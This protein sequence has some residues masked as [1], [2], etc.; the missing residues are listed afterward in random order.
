MSWRGEPFLPH[1]QLKFSNISEWKAG[2]YLS[3]FY[4][5]SGREQQNSPFCPCGSS[6]IP[7]QW[8]L[9]SIPWAYGPLSPSTP[10]AGLPLPRPY[11][12]DPY[13][14]QC[15]WCCRSFCCTTLNMLS[16]FSCCRSIYFNERHFPRVPCCWAAGAAWFLGLPQS[17]SRCAGAGRVTKGTNQ[18][19]AGK[20]SACGADT[21][22]GCSVFT[23]GFG[24]LSKRNEKCESMVS[25]ELCS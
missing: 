5:H 11:C 10:K 23:E 14:S 17:R 3:V 25:I 15:F 9:S 22:L 6:N 4:Y 20:A 18:V 16:V 19:W 7:A 8:G 21:P 12:L 24:Y 13:L 2:F 1:S